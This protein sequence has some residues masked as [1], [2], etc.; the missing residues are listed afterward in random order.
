MLYEQGVSSPVSH[1]KLQNVL[2]KAGLTTGAAYRLWEDQ[3]AFQHDLAAEATRR[4]DAKMVGSL[5][6]AVRDLIEARAPLTEIIRVA[7]N[8]H[9][10]EIFGT[11]RVN[12]LQ[13][14]MVLINIAMRATAHSSDELRRASRE[15]HQEAVGSYV[16]L[17]EALQQLGGLTMRAPY[18][19]DHF[20]L[21]LA[22]LAEGFT[23]QAIQG[24]PHAVIKV[25]DE[26]G[27]LQEWT[28]FGRVVM[29][30]VDTFMQPVDP[31]ADR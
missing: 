13:D 2:R 14:V 18:T 27:A 17:Y 15:W 28:L 11:D 6:E 21:A 19:M 12:P 26:H 24:S 20:S 1:I 16:A 7:T 4:K 29:S 3:S 10:V 5:V 30:L 9:V 23:L 8:Q 25:P 31:P 22:A